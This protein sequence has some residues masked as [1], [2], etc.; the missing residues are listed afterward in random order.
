MTGEVNRVPRGLLSL[1]D[2][3]ARGQVPRMLSSELSGSLELLE[4]YLLQNRSSVQGT[5]VI[6]AVGNF[7]FTG[8]VVPQDEIWY[9]W[10][11][12]MQPTAALV[13]AGGLIR[14]AAG[15]FVQP[16]TR[17]HQLGD[18]IGYQAQAGDLPTAIARGGW[19]AGPGDFP[20]CFVSEFTAF[21]PNPTMNVDVLRTVLKV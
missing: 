17:P 9:V 8:P 11:V 13:G 3:Q 21:A 1:L 19:W 20:C 7:N 6:N 15:W 4:L 12:T 10:Q 14:F 18:E 16:N 5:V 2:M